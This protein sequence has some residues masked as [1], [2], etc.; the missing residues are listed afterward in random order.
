[1]P[2]IFT[3]IDPLSFILNDEVASS[4]EALRHIKPIMQSVSLKTGLVKVKIRTHHA[5]RFP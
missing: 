1:V 4:G 5:G 2:L 3:A